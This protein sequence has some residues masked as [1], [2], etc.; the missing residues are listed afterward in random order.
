MTEDSFRQLALS[1]PESM[2]SS[3]MGH[4]DFRVKNKIF[5]TLFTGDDDADDAMVKLTPEQQEEFIATNPETFTPIKGAWGERGYTQVRL[6]TANQA[7]VKRAIVTAW[8]NT[9]P[10]GLV[11]KFKLQ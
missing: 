3:H 6:A 11:N 4:P 5:A 7:A 9:A 1:M 2:E 10:K 8:K